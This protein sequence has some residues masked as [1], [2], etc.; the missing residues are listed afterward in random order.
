MVLIPATEVTTG[1]GL[2]NCLADSLLAYNEPWAR[3]KLKSIT[4]MKRNVHEMTVEQII[5]AIDQADNDLAHAGIPP[6]IQDNGESE[7]SRIADYI[8][9]ECSMMEHVSRGRFSSGDKYILFDND[10]AT[11]YTFTTKDELFEYLPADTI[12]EIINDCED[13]EPEA[14]AVWPSPQSLVICIDKT[15][16]KDDIKSAPRETLENLIL[17]L[18]DSLS[19]AAGT[20]PDWWDREN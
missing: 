12:Q 15:F 20:Y 3:C 18:Y 4:T 6:Y 1:S 17:Y 2:A 14:P 13:D 11:I 9:D 7:R 16:A 19:H 10:N 5:S 8:D